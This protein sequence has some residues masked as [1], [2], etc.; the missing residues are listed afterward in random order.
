M[1][2]K[3]HIPTRITGGLSVWTEGSPASIIINDA[4]FGAV[5]PVSYT[6]TADSAS[7]SLTG[8]DA[9]LKASRQ[10]IAA[11]SS[12]TEANANLTFKVDRK[13]V[14]DKYDLSLSGQST[15]LNKGFLLTT[16]KADYSLTYI[17]NF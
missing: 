8:N 16:V 11:Q 4:F 10:I 15:I 2:N 13:I 17:S 5:G 6:L 3:L 1:A 14:V 12:F 9:G 7:F